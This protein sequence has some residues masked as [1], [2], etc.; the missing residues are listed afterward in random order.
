[1][2]TFCRYVREDLVMA[3]MHYAR[4]GLN[5]PH[6]VF[7]TALFN[8][9]IGAQGKLEAAQV[10][11][12]KQ[13][14]GART[15]A[16][17]EA[18]LLACATQG[19]WSR[20]RN[21]ATQGLIAS[22]S[23]ETADKLLQRCL[24]PATLAEDL[25]AEFLQGVGHAYTDRFQ[26]ALLLIDSGAFGEASGLKAQDLVESFSSS[27]TGNALLH[28]HLTPRWLADHGIR[29]ED[30]ALSVIPLEKRDLDAEVDHAAPLPT[31]QPEPVQVP[32]SN[33]AAASSSPTAP[34]DPDAMD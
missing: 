9:C 26:A 27:M 8:K 4:A 21:M 29:E 23:R 18:L 20:A 3:A 10:L 15:A 32:L 12:E 34:A 16:F 25:K 19:K 28:A 2:R 5:D 22:V 1:M 24:E 6:Q 31:P 33:G 17:A 7:A 14:F 11:V 13:V 30:W